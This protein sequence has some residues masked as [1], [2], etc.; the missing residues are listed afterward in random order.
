MSFN[1]MAAVTICSDFGD[2]K[3]KISYCF[4]RVDSCSLLQE[5]FPNPGIEP[6]SQTLQA[7]SLPAEPPGKPKNTGVGRLYVKFSS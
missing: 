6:K 7:G 2:Q 5:I 3:N 1:F 4:Q